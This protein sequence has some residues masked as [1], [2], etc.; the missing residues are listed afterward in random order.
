MSEWVKMYVNS[1]VDSTTIYIWI[2]VLSMKVESHP[3]NKL[4]L[5]RPY[6]RVDNEVSILSTCVD[7]QVDLSFSFASN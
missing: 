5:H 1:A 6:I 4:P 2:V 7:A 3:G